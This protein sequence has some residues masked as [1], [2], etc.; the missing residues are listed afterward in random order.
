[1]NMAARTEATCPPGCIQMTH[2]AYE[3][4]APVL[5]SRVV[6]KERGEVTVKGREQPLVMY[7]VAGRRECEDLDSSA[8]SRSISR[9]MKDLEEDF[10]EL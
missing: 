6:F 3:L 4:A 8:P 9:A 5:G 1:M 2:T 7:L 10:V